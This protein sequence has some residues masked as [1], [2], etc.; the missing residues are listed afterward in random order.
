MNTGTLIL[1]DL[2]RLDGLS[3]TLFGLI[4]FIGVILMRY[5]WT[6]LGGEPGRVRFMSWFLATLG[7]VALVV[8]SNHLLLLAMAWTATSLCLHRLL[9]FYPDR[10]AAVLAAHKK[11]L[12]S[13]AADIS[14]L[15]GIILVGQNFG[16]FRIDSILLTASAGELPESGS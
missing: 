2:L 14:L 4:S 15:A 9:V 3:L 11:F 12:L 7:S 1:W 6:Y 16:S 8:L 13:R 5:S 10:P